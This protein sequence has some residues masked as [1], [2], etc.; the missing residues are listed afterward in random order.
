[1][2]LQGNYY[3]LHFVGEGTEAQRYR[4]L[5]RATPL[6]IMVGELNL[7]SVCALDLRSL[8]H[9]RCFSEFRVQGINEAAF[10]GPEVTSVPPT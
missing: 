1:M 2:A 3:H 5:P 4:G 10:V 9:P 8:P 6:V 7:S